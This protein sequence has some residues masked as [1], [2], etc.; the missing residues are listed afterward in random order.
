MEEQLMKNENIKEMS[1]E[2]VKSAINLCTE[3]VKK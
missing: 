2:E 3:Y 1:L